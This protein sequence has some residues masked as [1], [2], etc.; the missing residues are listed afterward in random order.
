MHY[1]ITIGSETK[2]VATDKIETPN[3]KKYSIVSDKKKFRIEIL[4]QNK[5]NLIVSLD[6][7]VYSLTIIKRSP[8]RVIFAANRKIIEALIKDRASPKQ[9]Y[10]I[11]VP[12]DGLIKSNFPAK[13]I[14]INARTGD[15]LNKGDTIIVLEAM[16]MEAQIRVPNSCV[17][18]EIFVKEG[19]MVER[20]KTLARLESR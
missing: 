6:E 18:K 5:S 14:K 10:S 3:G 7:K 9:D 19:E 4:S 1:E 20:G 13:I 2:D 15:S 16:K 12:R 8:S 11:A 17:V